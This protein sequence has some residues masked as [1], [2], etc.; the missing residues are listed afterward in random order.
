MVQTQSNLFPHLCKTGAVLHVPLF[1]LFLRLCKTGAVLR[2]HLR[3]RR[4]KLK[5]AFQNIKFE[6]A[7]P[8]HLS[9]SESLFRVCLTWVEEAALTPAECIQ[10]T[11]P[12]IRCHGLYRPP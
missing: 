2:V 8:A 9:R 3:R 4:L 11:G 7:V 5:E 10:T 1:R 6:E 12:H